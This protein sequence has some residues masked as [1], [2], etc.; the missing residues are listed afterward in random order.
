MKVRPVKESFKFQTIRYVETGYVYYFI[1]V[2]Q[3]NSA[4]E[5]G[6]E[7]INIILILLDDILKRNKKICLWNKQQFTYS[8][9]IV[10][11]RN[12]GIHVVGIA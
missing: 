1:L 4:N 3:I 9:V 8:K 6:K 2:T 10:G 5:E 12:K 11:A 7:V